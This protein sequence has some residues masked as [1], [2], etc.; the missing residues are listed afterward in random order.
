MPCNC[1]KTM[2]AFIQDN[3]D[4]VDWGPILWKYLH[5]LSENIG[6]SGNSIVDTDQANYMET[7]ITT[8]HLILPCKECQGHTASYIALTPFHV[9]GM[10]GDTLRNTVRG[11]LFM[12][13]NHVRTIKGQPIE[14]NTLEEYSAIYRGNVI[15]KSEYA[16][17]VQSVASAVRQGFV[18]IDHWRKWYSNSERLRII[19]GN[20]VI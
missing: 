16:F 2:T 9:K 6:I 14:I 5:C 17:I 1:K 20:V 11:W 4:S 7:L 8:L 18:R 13:H 10:H 15:S 3:I 19:S 12:F